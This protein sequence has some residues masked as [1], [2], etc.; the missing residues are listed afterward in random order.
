MIFVF[1]TGFSLSTVVLSVNF[2]IISEGPFGFLIFKGI[3]IKQAR[4][5][6]WNIWI[7]SLLPAAFTSW[8]METALSW[9]ER[10]TF[11]SFCFFLQLTTWYR[12]FEVNVNIL[13]ASQRRKTVNSLNSLKFH[14]FNQSFNIFF[15][16]TSIPYLLRRTILCTL[17]RKAEGTY[18]KN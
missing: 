8:S 4:H 16:F 15:F 3:D 9:E 1:S 13:F 18:F 17:F 5:I 2:W 11:S 12:E 6:F 14:C 10:C 7:S